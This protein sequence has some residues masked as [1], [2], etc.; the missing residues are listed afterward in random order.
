MVCVFQP[1]PCK[2]FDK[3][4]VCSTICRIMVLCESARW[5]TAAGEKM[6]TGSITALVTPFQEDSSIDWNA[7]EALLERQIASG[8]HGVVPCGTTGESPALSHDEDKRIVARCVEIVKKRV[9]VIAGTGSNNT[10]EAIELTRHAEEAGADAALVITPYYNKPTQDGLYAHYRA[11]AESVSIPLILYN[12]PGRTGVD[13]SNETVARLAADIPNI[14]GI[15][16]ATGNL[17]RPTLLRGLAG[18]DFCQLSGED[19]TAAA[20]L[21]QGGHGCIS[22]T[23]NVAP[24]ECAELQVA[25]QRGNIAEVERLRDLL[26]PLHKALFF[27]T[28][29]GPVKYALSRLGL[30]ADRLRLPLIPVSPSCRE[31]VD[32]AMDFAGLSANTQNTLSARAAE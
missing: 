25:W 14:V 21:A 4:V 28:S 30:C 24:D 26:A 17:E 9:P 23:A 19:G 6:F 29:P 18:K 3:S 8:S 7:F 32:A 12:V 2:G 16:D 11:V 27:E 13:I 31:A 10:V 22:V 5:D 15:K 1:L 20:F